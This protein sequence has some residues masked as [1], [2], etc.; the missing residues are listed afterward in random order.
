[1]KKRLA[2]AAIGVACVLVGWAPNAFG[3]YDMH[4]NVYEWVEDCWNASY[5]GAPSDGTPW[6][7]GECA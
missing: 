6:L 2:V 4:G 7:R 3:L 5:V 1:M